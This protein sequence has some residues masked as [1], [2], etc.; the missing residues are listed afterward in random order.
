MGGKQ[1]ES[2]VVYLRAFPVFSGRTE[3]CHGK[4]VWI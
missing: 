2:V 1:K 4:P 3:E